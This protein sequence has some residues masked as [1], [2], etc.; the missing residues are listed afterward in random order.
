[1]GKE[2]ICR[3]TVRC[4]LLGKGGK[5]KRET[6]PDDQRCL[7]LGRKNPISSHTVLRRDLEVDLR[8]RVGRKNYTASW[9][10]KESMGNCSG[11]FALGDAILNKDP[12]NRPLAS[13]LARREIDNG[14][15]IA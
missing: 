9:R 2:L 13:P 7:G 10:S 6:Y 4:T 12:C 5:G 1:M 11:I 8:R 15:F 3:N 14:C